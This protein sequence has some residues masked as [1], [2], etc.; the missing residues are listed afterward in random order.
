MPRIQ[1]VDNAIVTMNLIRPLLKQMGRDFHTCE[2]C[3]EHFDEELGVHHPKYE[4]CTIHDLVI[5]CN[6]C[7]LQSERTNLV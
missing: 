5:C 6:K 4:G 2:V 7:N 1:N 3:G